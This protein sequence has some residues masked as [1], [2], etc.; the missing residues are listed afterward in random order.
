MKSLKQYITEAFDKPY[1]WQLKQDDEIQAK[2]QSVTD[3]GDKLK[4]T[5]SKGWSRGIDNI[6]F[7]VAGETGITGEGDAFRIMA[8]VLD[9]IKDYIVNHEPKG[10]KFTANK[11]E[12]FGVD[13]KEAQSREKLYTKMIERFAKKAGY[14]V[15]LDKNKYSTNYKLIRK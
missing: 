9:I 11:E 3:A 4:V 6:I 7:T 5:F 13:S 1:R 14:Q 12:Y 8:T 15:K 2:Y 10:M